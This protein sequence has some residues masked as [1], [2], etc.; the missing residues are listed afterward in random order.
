MA[1]N[2]PIEWTDHTFNPWWGCTKV[3][4]GC[5]HCYA[6]QLDRRTGGNHWGPTANRRLV[7]D[8][9]GP[10]RWNRRAESSESAWRRGVETVGG[11]D[12]SALIDRGFIKP[13]RPRV[14]CASMADVFDDHP[15]ILPEWRQ[16]LWDL[17]RD[18][19][20]LDWLMLTKRPENIRAMLPAD[21]GYGWPHVWLGTSAEDQTAADERI[22]HL[23][24]APAAKRFLSCEPL[25]GPV[26]MERWLNIVWQ[27][28]GCKGYFTGRHR[29]ICPDCDKEGFWTGSHAFNGRARPPSA[30]IPPQ[31]GRGI[32]WIIVG[33]ESG[34]QARPM[35]PE[36]ARSLRDQCN[37]AGVP[38]LFKQWGEWAPATDDEIPTQFGDACKPFR[39]LC[40][41]GFVGELSLESGLLHKPARWPQ[42]F[43]DGEE[44]ESSCN[45]VF[46]RR[47]GKKA[48][49]RLLDGRE[50]NE[51]PE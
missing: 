42:C 20:H 27:C 15:S 43:P 10:R 22:P 35:H 31:S 11:G 8:W 50:W 45:P 51:V 49:G 16:R 32:D 26:S 36:W 3:S 25:L 46:I 37:A 24:S 14:F 13:R 30:I 34:P 19:P 33:G 40:S 21:W 48:A 38:F 12:E 1:E 44:G 7:K 29:E 28:C 4:E 41:N 23:L 39:T 9:S 6:D 17:I 18:T 47:V 2:S 5:K